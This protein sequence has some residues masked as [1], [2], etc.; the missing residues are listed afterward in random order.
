MDTDLRR[1]HRRWLRRWLRFSLR[2]C[3]LAVLVAAVLSV[4]YDRAIKRYSPPVAPNLAAPVD[5]NFHKA[6]LH[7]VLD[8]LAEQA[9]TSVNF[10]APSV[11]AM[12]DHPVTIHLDRSISTKSALN[13]VLQPL[14]LEHRLQRNQ[15]VICNEGG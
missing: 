13:L 2:F 5:L 14:G 12:A 9:G 3:F 8:Y 4:H 15:L 6:A 7:D 10:D 1:A 11:V